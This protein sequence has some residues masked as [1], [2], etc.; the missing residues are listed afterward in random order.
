VLIDFDNIVP[1]DCRQAFLNIPTTWGLDEEVVNALTEM[2]AAML[3][4]SRDYQNLVQDFV[5]SLADLP[6]GV[7]SSAQEHAKKACERLTSAVP[8]ARPGI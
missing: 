4:S 7:A 2:G 5:T 1:D 8:A 3:A 6:D